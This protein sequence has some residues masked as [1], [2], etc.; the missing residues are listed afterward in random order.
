[1]LCI[2]GSSS[3]AAPRAARHH[4]R[5]AARP[6]RHGEVDGG[7]GRAGEVALPHVADDADDRRPLRLGAE[8]VH[9]FRA[10]LLAERV[11]AGPEE[12]GRGTV[13][14]GGVRV[15]RV[16]ARVE[17]TAGD[18]RDAHGVE[19][20]AAGDAIRSVGAAA[21]ARAHLPGGIELVERGLG[22]DSGGGDAGARGERADEPLLKARHGRIVRVTA[23][24]W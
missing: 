13:D 15:A 6:L 24:R 5:V 20:A 21:A 16:V 3:P 22:N 9:A 11:L 12:L 7:I 1:V 4:H 14:D 10:D 17:E 8:L 2:T 19:V 18:E 23:L